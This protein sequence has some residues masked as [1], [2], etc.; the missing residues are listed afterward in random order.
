MWSNPVRFLLVYVAGMVLAAACAWAFGN[1]LVTAY[2][3][4]ILVF[5]PASRD[6]PPEISDSFRIGMAM[7]WFFSALLFALLSFS[8]YLLTRFSRIT[9]I[10]LSMPFL[11]ASITCA[12]FMVISVQLSG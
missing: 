2:P 4:G 9:L 8:N 11:L 1:G 12:V 6:I 10:Y 3:E 7:G 5:P